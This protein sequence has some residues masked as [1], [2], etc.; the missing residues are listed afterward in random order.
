VATPRAKAAPAAAPAP[1]AP[2]SDPKAFAAQF[3]LAAECEAAARKQRAAAPDT[4]WA[5]LKA[6]VDRGKFSALHKLLEGDWDEDFQTRPDAAPLLTRVIAAR[7]GD[8]EGDLSLLRQRRVPLFSLAA[9][10]AQPATYKGKNILL[11]A[12]VTEARAES[13]KPTVLLSEFALGAQTSDVEVGTAHVS[14]SNSSS[15][16]NASA[17]VNT[18][19]YG[20]A[21]GKAD[22]ARSSSSDYRSATTKKRHDNVAVE[23]GRQALGRLSKPDPFLEPGRDFVVLARFDG[24]RKMASDETEDTPGVAVLSIVSYAEPASLLFE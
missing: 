23:T 5:I 3:T 13:G 12:Q 9:A 1:V 19:R 7:G 6:C 8:L 11:R 16:A 2:P 24:V 22:Y 21:S 15:R 20:S 18:S 17:K 4:G 10:L 14:S